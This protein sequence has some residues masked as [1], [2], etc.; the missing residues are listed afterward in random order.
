MGA[1]ERL[2]EKREINTERKKLIDSI[3]ILT[4]RVLNLKQKPY[5]MVNTHWKLMLKLGILIKNVHDFDVGYSRDKLSGDVTL[6]NDLIVRVSEAEDSVPKTNKILIKSPHYLAGR[7][8]NISNQ[9]FMLGK[10]LVRA[11]DAFD[12]N[13]LL[14]KEFLNNNR[15]LWEYI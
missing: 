9:D 1:E 7:L 14:T 13:T 5:P 10:V 12:D 8:F 11:H 15:H 3:P 4:S 6:F 2:K